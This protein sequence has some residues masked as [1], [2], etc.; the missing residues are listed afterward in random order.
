MR[1]GPPT[2]ELTAAGVGVRV[3]V[4]RGGRALA[5]DVPVADVKLSAS[6]E[7][8]VPQQISFSAPLDWVPVGALDPL[9]NFGQRVQV[10]ALVEHEAPV[11]INLGWFQIDSWNEGD[12]AVSVKASDLMRVLDE[13]PM[14]WPSSPAKNATL[15]SELRRLCSIADGGG[16]S[17]VLDV[18]DF[19][20]DSTLQWD[21]SRTTSI[22]D[23][24]TSY[25]LEYGVKAD[26]RLHVWEKLT[27]RDPVAHYSGRDL[28]VGAP[29]SSQARRA[30]RF[31]VVGSN[32]DSDNEKRYSSVVKANTPPFDFSGYGVV[33][34]RIELSGATTQ[35]AVTKAATAAMRDA[36]SVAE[37]RTLEIV[38]DP[39]LELGDIISVLTDAGEPLV[40]RVTAISADFSN[41]DQTMRAD[42]EVLKW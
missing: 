34:S 15:E 12:D 2:A 22:Q 21:T 29:R 7:Q 26:G 5:A 13:N 28:L 33:T 9:N 35:A 41:V 8:V 31:I 20:I 11:G 30:N 14:D 32:G 40:G 3:N 25:G 39:R 10:V 36:L 37:T 6:T 17:V 1:S 19:T 38:L 4:A 16:L 42:V 18:D 27:G 24:C 23:L